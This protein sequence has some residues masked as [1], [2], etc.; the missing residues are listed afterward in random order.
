MHSRRGSK[1]RRT[2]EGAEQPDAGS[3]R[4]E[5]ETSAPANDPD[6]L[7]E[8]LERRGRRRLDRFALTIHFGRHR[9]PHPYRY[10]GD[11]DIHRCLDYA[12]ACG[13]EDLHI[14]MVDHFLRTC[15]TLSFP[16]GFS[17]L[18]RLSLLR[19][20]RVSFGYSLS[21]DAFPA[22]EVIHLRSARSV[23]L[24]HLLSASPRLR[25]LDLRYCQSL[26]TLGA[27]NIMPARGHLRSLTVAE[28]DRLTH[29][30]AGTAS[31]LLSLR[32]SSALLPTYDILSTAPL[33]DLYI[34]LRGPTCLTKLRNLPSLRELQLLM[35]ATTS[36]N[37]AHIY[38]FLR[39]CRCPQLERLFVQLPTCSH[40]TFMGNSSEERLYYEDM[41]DEDP[42]DGNVP[43]EE[44]PE[45]DVP[46]YGL[47][48]LM[49][50]KMM[51]FKGHYFEMR[52]V[53]FLL[54]KAPG[55][56][57]LLLVAPKGHIKALGKHTLDISHLI[58]SKLPRSRRASPDSQII[59]SETDFAA[60]QPVHSDVFA[61]F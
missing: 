8:S 46:E 11:K 54:R 32:L 42:L 52:L 16:S 60:S 21:S 59:L 25:T 33:E 10:L 40:D 24:N 39:T 55:L 13:V 27:I 22:L 58:D 29:L 14:D 35:F 26:D 37:L 5:K 28:C 47:N 23:D 9:F 1:R 4:P 36:T 18:V 50:A 53:I 51:K 43:Q 15:S 48:N 44:Q 38:M 20:G 57:K 12:A 49:I 7:L 45:E 34:C 3:L 17:R 61:R 6:R 19:V 56:K 2:D 41:Y 30:Y 31:G